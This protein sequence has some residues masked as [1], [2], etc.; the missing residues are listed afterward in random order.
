MCLRVCKRAAFGMEHLP[1]RLAPRPVYFLLPGAVAK[2]VSGRNHRSVFVLYRSK[3]LESRALLRRWTLPHASGSWF[4]DEDKSVFQ[5]PH[6]WLSTWFWDKPILM[7]SICGR[8]TQVYFWHHYTSRSLYQN[9]GAS[10]VTNRSLWEAWPLY[11]ELCSDIV[12]LESERWQKSSWVRSPRMVRMSRLGAQT[13]EV[14]REEFGFRFF[15]S[16]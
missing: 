11:V 14:F 13:V 5:E 2:A 16:V 10:N 1:R 12:L 15:W 8:K 9:S 6:P 4:F 7:N 3:H